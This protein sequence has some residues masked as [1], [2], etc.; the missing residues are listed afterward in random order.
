MKP[1][2]ND[3]LDQL[4]T[5]LLLGSKRA[6]NRFVFAAHQTN[7]ATHNRLT[8]R[9]AAYYEARAAG[10]AG[11]IVLE[12]SVVHPSD[13][14]YEYAVFGHDPAVVD[15][16]RQVAKAVHRHGALVLAHL[17]H[18][19]MQGSSHYSQL[20]LWAP[21]PVPEVNSRE[22]PQA[23]DAE[24]ITAV[25]EGFR[26]AARYASDG[27]L[28]GVELNAGQDSLIRQ[29][30]SPLTNQRGDQYGGSLENR[31]RFARQVIE[32]VRN[33]IGRNAIVG[34]RLVGDEYA[35]WA[36]I[37]PEDAA[38]IARHLGGD[39]LLDFISVTSGSIYTGH[40]TRPGLFQ[41]PG[42]AVHLAA[43][44]K[45]AVTLP[46]FAQGSIVDPAMAAALLAEGKADAVE[47]TRALI[48]DPELPT[49][50]RQG[51]ADD[52]RPCLLANQD[53]II[54]LVQNPGLSCAN[55][56]AAGYERE[57]EFAPLKPA[58]IRHRV[59]IVGGGPA[60][61]E[62]ARVAALRGHRVTLYER[63]HRL[64][65]AIRLAAAAP[66][67]ERLALAVDWLEAQVRKLDVEIQ[68]G[69]E[70]TAERVIAA[71]PD[72]VIVA[73]GGIPGRQAGVCFHETAPVVNPRQVM[74]GEAPTAPGRA[75]ILDTLGDPVG[76]GVAEWLAE[77]GW[78]VE[79]VTRDMF[80][81]QRLTASLEL[82]AWNQRA[83]VRGIR[84]RPQFDALEVT[85]RSVM[86]ADLFDHR[87]IRFD[88]I[89]LV[90]DVSPEMPDEA[91]YFAL[92]SSGLR[93]F[94]A[95]DCVAPR[96]LSHAILEGYRAGREA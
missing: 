12:G 34:L 47:M 54:G 85:A 73:V 36:G 3:A 7:F 21:S 39:R 68:T 87:E 84:F 40:L 81:G 82:T 55:N 67:R 61:L 28:D 14:P 49:K 6:S 45:A 8:E 52:I 92:K 50:L 83:A 1:S 29:F 16:Y 75:V 95:G 88:E 43:L 10:G 15:G 25:I 69:I 72:A 53:N 46:V 59:L 66:G 62:A 93:V 23:M 22:L 33:G 27:G 32:A 65:G 90:V 89:D 74:S 9:H 79:V 64:G 38:E 42:F 94:R 24:D 11:L 41:P 86:G 31:L 77:R 56:P 63:S 37:K 19:G 76:M 13:W 44:V 78:Q 35:P 48:A 96:Y 58:R 91:L 71:A 57:A 30:L 18:S 51:Q 60:G 26:Q 80:V 17:T 70:M 5:P 20:P 4:F 2:V